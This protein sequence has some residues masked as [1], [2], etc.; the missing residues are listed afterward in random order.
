MLDLLGLFQHD[1]QQA[2]LPVDIQPQAHH[3]LSALPLSFTAIVYA[4]GDNLP[5]PKPK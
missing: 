2:V 1:T 3:A 4:G 5:P